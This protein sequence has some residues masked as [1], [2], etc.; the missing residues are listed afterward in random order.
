M[1][2]KISKE[3]DYLKLKM[4]RDFL[5]EL[6]KHGKK[7]N[8]KIADWSMKPVWSGTKLLQLQLRALKEILKLKKSGHW[9]WDYVLNLSES[10]FPIK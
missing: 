3:A 8:F 10:D 9:D 7:A 5:S 2:K 1:K 4:R 6:E